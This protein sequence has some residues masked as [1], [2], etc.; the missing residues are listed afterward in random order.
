M[1]EIIETEKKERVKSK[2]LK[3]RKPKIEI[4]TEPEIIPI[5]LN[6]TPN[7]TPTS[8]AL[9]D[10]VIVKAPKKKRVM[11]EAQKEA[12]AKGR[13]KAHEKLANMRNLAKQQ[14]LLNDEKKN[15]LHEFKSHKI[16]EE[17]EEKPDKP[18]RTR[19][20]KAQLEKEKKQYELDM[21]ALELKDIEMNL[22]ITK[23][24]EKSKPPTP[25][26]ATPAQM[27]RITRPKP[28][29]QAP[30]PPI[31]HNNTHGVFSPDKVNDPQPQRQPQAQ[32]YKF[33]IDK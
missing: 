21:K 25:A 1:S 12:F 26:P 30:P 7:T 31:F 19:K 6:D 16:I 2:L 11:S 27:G 15:E 28:A 17:P 23:K 13:K 9:D 29:F 32:K 10:K 33:Y 8:E 4:N 24:K 22:K 5:E 18:K 20:T 3:D 14:Q